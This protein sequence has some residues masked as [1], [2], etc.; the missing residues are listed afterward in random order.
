M[1]TNN[2]AARTARILPN[3]CAQLSSLDLSLSS[4]KLAMFSSF[5]PRQEIAQ[6]EKLAR[7][8]GQKLPKNCTDLFF[9]PEN[10]SLRQIGRA[11]V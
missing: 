6:V 2:R 1:M 3:F 4:V 7:Y 10:T 9:L 5:R 11:H 8:I